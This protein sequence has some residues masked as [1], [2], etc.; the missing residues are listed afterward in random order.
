M[1]HFAPLER[2]G[3]RGGIADLPFFAARRKYAGLR[4]ADCAGEEP[5]FWIL[6]FG[7]WIRTLR[8]CRSDVRKGSAFPRAT[9]THLESRLRL[10]TT[11]MSQRRIGEAE[12]RLYF[13]WLSLRKGGA[14]PHSGAAEPQCPKSLAPYPSALPLKMQR[15]ATSWRGVSQG[16]CPLLSAFVRF[17]NGFGELRWGSR[18]GFVRFLAGIAAHLWRLRILRPDT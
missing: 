6:D 11:T 17:L 9:H 7:F 18:A 1:H 16:A 4:I 3:G 5:R 15:F 8:L 13:L 14:F 12:P 2:G 10:D